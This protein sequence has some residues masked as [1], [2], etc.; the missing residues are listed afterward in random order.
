MCSSARRMRRRCS[1]GSS[2]AATGASSSGMG[3]GRGPP[4][5]SRERGHR[6]GIVTH[7]AHAGFADFGDRRIAQPMRLAQLRRGT[8]IGVPGALQVA[9]TLVGQETDPARD[10]VQRGARGQA[11]FGFRIRALDCAR[12][13]RKSGTPIAR[14]WPKIATNKGD[15][16]S[17]ARA[18]GARPATR[19]A[20][21]TWTA[22]TRP[23]GAT[24]A[25]LSGATAVAP[26][27]TTQRSS[28]P[29]PCTRA[30]A[31]TSAWRSSTPGA[32]SA[33]GA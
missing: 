4:Q 12:P 21:Q 22:I 2:K 23:L 6:R 3:G 33:P 14:S 28:T 9:S 18:T 17:A 16:P 7:H 10:R 5:A 13:G 1:S 27:Q 31:P 19:A 15:P 32:T 29:R 26:G 25:S 24:M 30:P 11:Q 8:G 20:A